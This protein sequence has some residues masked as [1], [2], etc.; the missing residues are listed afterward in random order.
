MQTMK[1]VMF[2]TTTQSWT[3]KV[4]KSYVCW[5]LFFFKVF[6]GHMSIF[7][8]NGTPVLDFWWCLLWVSKP[9]SAA[10]IALRR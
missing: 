9:E 7:G 10:L 1:S 6:G 8:A 4:E 5:N 3:K 2:K